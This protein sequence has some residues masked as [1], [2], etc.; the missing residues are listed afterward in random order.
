MGTYEEK[1]Y[2]ELYN[3]DERNKSVYPWKGQIV[4]G[5]F[6]SES[7]EQI[8]SDYFLN[9]KHEEGRGSTLSTEYERLRKW[10]DAKHARALHEKIYGN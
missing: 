2:N 10:K 5:A 4:S 3:P 1:R 9:S 8:T 7:I 6:S